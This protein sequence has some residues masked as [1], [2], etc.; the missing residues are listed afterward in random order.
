MLN[1]SHLVVKQEATAGAANTVHNG[2][3]VWSRVNITMMPP[4]LHLKPANRDQA[5]THPAVLRCRATLPPRLPEI[6]LEPWVTRATPGSAT[7]SVPP[8]RSRSASKGP[9]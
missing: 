5:R 3:Q 2:A 6:N 9:A 1:A 7:K 8:Q 4:R